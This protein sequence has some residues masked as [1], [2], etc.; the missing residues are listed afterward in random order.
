LLDA[1]VLYPAPLR[2]LLLSL[3][4][5]CPIRL[6]WSAAIHEEWIRNLLVQRPDLTR[7][8]LERTRA[9]MD[10]AFP[11]AVVEGFEPL[12]GSLAMPDCDDRH[13]LAA[14][15]Q[16]GAD[17]IVTWN[18]KDFP[19]KLLAK[20]RLVRQTP[21][22]FVMAMIATHEPLVI[23]AVHALRSRLRRPAIS[24]SVLLENFAQQGLAEVVAHLGQARIIDQL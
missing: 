8:Q 12:I 13:V 11:D 19:V 2:D 20:H 22:A 10:Q 16:A 24:P 14:A 3:G 17:V 21:D 18:L 5:H 23:E 7:S 4:S 15:I 6:H 9:L 1:C